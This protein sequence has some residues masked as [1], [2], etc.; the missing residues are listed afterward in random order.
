[1]NA[2][3]RDFYQAFRGGAADTYDFQAVVERHLGVR[4]D[5][6]FDQWVRGTAIPTYHVAW[7]R[8][9]AAA[10]RFRVRL[11]ITQEHVPE[12]FRMPVLVAVDLGNN[13]VARFRVE[14]HGGQT[15]YTSPLLPGEPRE[16]TFNDFHSVLAEVRMERW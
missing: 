15:E 2:T 10:G 5:W 7:T 11:R 6:F 1:M 3:L 4:M 9:A 16:L 12:D 14:V 8:E 13:V